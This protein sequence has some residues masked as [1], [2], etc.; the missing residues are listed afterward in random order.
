MTIDWRHLPSLVTLRAFQA[1][2]QH[3]GFTGA[4]RALNVTHAAIAQQ[5]RALE[6][7]LGVPLVQRLGRAVS[8]TQQGEHLA[9]TLGDGFGTIAAGIAALQRREGERVLRVATTAF[10]AQSLILPRMAEFWALHP[11]VEVAM[12]PGFH[13]VDLLA[14][15][16]DLAIRGW[17]TEGPG[18]QTELLAES[19]WVLAG[20]PALLGDG[21]V[22]V[23]ALPWIVPDEGIIDFLGDAGIDTDRI[24]Q[25]R[26]GSPFLEMSA[27]VLGL[28]L[29]V[30]TE[31]IIRPDLASGRLREVPITGF[32]ST[33]YYATMPAGPRRAATDAFV[34]W[35]KT[36]F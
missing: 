11:G 28:G 19:R 9:Q 27:A 14:E 26:V 21:P 29:V 35:V 33:N 15:G 31:A 17:L 1:T 3:G 23:M 24:T 16:Y 10:I 13:T 20:A 25:V 34:N 8:L 36:L 22:D 30:A 7:E 4:G 32:P 18:I 2:A 5:V 12:T 6:R